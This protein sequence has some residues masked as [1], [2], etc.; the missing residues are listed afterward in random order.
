M[1]VIT[2][3]AFGELRNHVMASV[4]STHPIVTRVTILDTW[5][6]TNSKVVSFA[7]TILKDIYKHFIIDTEY[8]TV[9]KSKF[10]N[11][12]RSSILAASYKLFIC[13]EQKG[14]IILVGRPARAPLYPELSRS[15][16]SNRS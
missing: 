16:P 12:L 10:E 5:W 7:I 13:R 9:S 1:Y 3:A 8:I 6:P 11:F 4:P 15:W 2:E 14:S